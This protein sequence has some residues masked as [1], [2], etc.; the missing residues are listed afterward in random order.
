M[1]KLILKLL[2]RLVEKNTITQLSV[3]EQTELRQELAKAYK[4]G[5]FLKWLNEKEKSIFRIWKSG[6]EKDDNLL[7]GR[8]LE[9]ETIRQEL[10]TSHIEEEKR[11]IADAKR[12][13]E[14]EE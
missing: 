6:T 8:L 10:R 1:R 12:Q 4:S 14:T 2:F 13:K 11:K 5:I 7:R 9:I 3:V